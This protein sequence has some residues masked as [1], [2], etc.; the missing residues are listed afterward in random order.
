MPSVGEAPRL[1]EN[2]ARN[3]GWPVFPCRADK[4]PA[5]PHGFKDATTDPDK[6][7]ELWRSCPGP[8]IGIATGA[9][10]GLSVL[11][12]DAKHDA[13]RAWWPQHQHHIPPTRRYRTR[14]G[15]MHVYF[16][17]RPGI[18]NTQG[19][20]APGIDTRGDGGY[21]LYWFAAGLPCLDHSPLAP[22]PQWL[23]DLI[24]PP[25]APARAAAKCAANDDAALDALIRTV[26]EACEGERNGTLFWAAN[27][28]RERGVSR[29]DAENRLIPAAADA[30]L[31]ETEARRTLA[32][33]WRAP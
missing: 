22:W 13:A 14:S 18:G 26:R 16:R 12:L 21:I 15:G 4:R 24:N 25:P 32:S 27:R 33:A 2:V 28:M 31:P 30:G 23:V 9:V 10:S 6:I 20:I 1:A 29:S 7:A 3:C 5:T 17:H 8:L 19:R 11:D